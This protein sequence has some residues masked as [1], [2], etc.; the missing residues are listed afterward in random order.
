MR[1][2]FYNKLQIQKIP[3][4]N[5]MIPAREFNAR[6]RNKVIDSVKQRFDDEKINVN[7]EMLIDT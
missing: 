1:E 3:K 6:I 5:K 2:Q 7:R 4:E